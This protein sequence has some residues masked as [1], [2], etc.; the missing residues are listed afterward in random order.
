MSYLFSLGHP[1]PICFPWASLALF[2][3]LHFHGLFTNFFGFPRPNYLIPNSALPFPYF[4]CLHYFGAVVAHSHFSTSFTAHG[5]AIPFFPGFFKL[6]YFLKAHLSTSWT[7]DPLFLPLGP[8]GFAICLPI[9]CCPC[10]WAFLLSTWIL[11]NDPQQLTIHFRKKN[12]GIEKV[13]KKFDS[14][15]NSR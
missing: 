10:R 8:N 3:T 1:W 15:F 6:V 4:L 13:V 11:T 5:F 9:L 7:C 14:S 12:L 2:L